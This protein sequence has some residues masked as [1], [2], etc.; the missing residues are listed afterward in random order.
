M[1]VVLVKPEPLVGLGGY[2]PNA[3]AVRDFAQSQVKDLPQNLHSML[4]P[5]YCVAS[6]ARVV[7]DLI[8]ISTFEGLVAEEVDRLVVNA[9]ETLGGVRFCFDVLQTVCLVPAMWEDIERDLAANRV[10]RIC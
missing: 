1:R 5:V 4:G 6:R 8:V 7:V 10:P 9:R 2:P 3:V